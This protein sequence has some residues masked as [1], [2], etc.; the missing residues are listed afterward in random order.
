MRELIITSSLLFLFLTACT[1]DEGYQGQSAWVDYQEEVAKNKRS[2][3]SKAVF[4]D[5]MTSQNLGYKEIF[6]E[7]YISALGTKCT[8]IR[9]MIN[10]KVDGSVLCKLKDGKEIVYNDLTL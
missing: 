10:N 4:S 9:N 5:K 2:S 8:R 3:I 7:D 1:E 6:R